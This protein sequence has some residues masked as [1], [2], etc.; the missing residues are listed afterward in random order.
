MVL[1][2]EKIIWCVLKHAFLLFL[3]HAYS[4][5]FFCFSKTL[6]VELQPTDNQIYK[7]PVTDIVVL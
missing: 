4:L 2:N 7:K 6:H 1:L 5:L 3:L